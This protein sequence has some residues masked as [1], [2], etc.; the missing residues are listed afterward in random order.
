[1]MQHRRISEQEVKLM[2]ARLFFSRD[3]YLTAISWLILLCAFA[4]PVFAQTSEYTMKAIYL[5][6]FSRF[7]DWPKVADI[8][9]TSR[10]FILTVIGE[11]PFGESLA[12]VFKDQKILKKQVIISYVDSV[13]HI[14]SCHMLFIASSEKNNIDHIIDRVKDLGVL[15][16]GDTEGFAEKGVLINLYLAEGKV[17]FEVNEAAVKESEF[18]ISYH[19]MRMAK[20]VNSKEEVKK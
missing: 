6:R 3:L 17:R 1:M 9:D 16:V 11:N 14:D 18:N 15:T 12:A 8:E 10:P 19:L 20:I 4:S 7:I 13:E 5:E 2:R